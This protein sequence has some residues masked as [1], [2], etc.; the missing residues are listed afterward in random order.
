MYVHVYTN[1]HTHIF[2]VDISMFFLKKLFCLMAF[3]LFLGIQLK[4]MLKHLPPY[5][6]ILKPYES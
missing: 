2:H 6:P 3:I 4:L 1:K 5:F